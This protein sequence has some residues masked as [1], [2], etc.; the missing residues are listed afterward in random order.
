MYISKDDAKEIGRDRACKTRANRIIGEPPRQW[1]FYAQSLAEL[2]DERIETFKAKED[3][4][5][6]LPA[7]EYTPARV[8]WGARDWDLPT[9]PFELGR[10]RPQTEEERCIASN[11]LVRWMDTYYLVQEALGAGSVSI[12]RNHHTRRMGEDVKRIDDPHADTVITLDP[13][14]IA[15]CTEHPLSDD[16]DG[17]VST[18]ICNVVDRVLGGIREAAIQKRIDVVWHAARHE[19]VPPVV[20]RVTGEVLRA[21]PSEGVDPMSQLATEV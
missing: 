14:I 11:E 15:I 8:V 16:E 6:P 5:A 12:G 7:S 21:E 2:I 17:V 10:S 1:C 20:D 19:R 3:I 13:D 9:G 18:Y 4:M